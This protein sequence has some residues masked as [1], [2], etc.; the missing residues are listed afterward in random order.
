MGHRAM[1]CWESFNSIFLLKP[2]HN[3]NHMLF[4]LHKIM[5]NESWKRSQLN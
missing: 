1:A 2:E 4:K 5:R 3:R